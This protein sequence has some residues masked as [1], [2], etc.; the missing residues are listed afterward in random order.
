[1]FFAVSDREWVLNGAMVHVS[2]VGFDNGNEKSK[3][4]DGNVVLGIAANL[5]G[6]GDTTVALPLR[7]NELIGF[8]GVAQKAPFDITD[9][10]ATSMLLELNPNGRPNSDVLTPIRN[11]EDL[12]RRPRNV[13]NIDFGLDRSIQDAAG[14]ERPFEHIRT[15]VYPL[16]IAHREARQTRYWWLFARPCPDMRK[17]LVGLPRFLATPRVSKHRVFVWLSPEM[18]SDSA[19]VAFAS[20]DDHIFGLLHSR[21][22]EIW[23]LAQGTQL[24]EKESGFRYT[25]STCFESF[26]FPRLTD[27][28]KAAI[29]VA[30]QELNQLRERWLNPPEWTLEKFLEFPGTVGGP[31]DRYI[32]KS[33]VPPNSQIGPVRYPR[34]EPRD[35][36]CAAKLKDR[37]LTKLYNQRPAWLDLAHK[38]LDAAVA[39]AYG[40]PADISD[41][42]IL[43][44]LLALNLERAAQEAQETAVNQ[45]TAQRGRR[46]DEMI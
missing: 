39:E 36:E 34:L 44:K 31:W 12:T 7:E 23:A 30:A 43:E 6:N 24:R 8:I 41:E 21:F 1:I 10:E 40:F 2:M 26:P 19:I 9:A 11:A 14:Y 18:L 20:A 38:K 32:D 3:Q 27:V 13:W 37:T 22:H 4:L 45:P 5:K 28:Q 35:A 16:R 17:A 46:S 15:V 25:P 33:T 29:A 42:Q